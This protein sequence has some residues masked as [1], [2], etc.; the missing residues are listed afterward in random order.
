MRSIGRKRVWISLLIIVAAAVAAIVIFHRSEP[1]VTPLPTVEVEP[2]EVDD[3][4][5]Y[6]EFV[7]RIRAQQFVEVRARPFS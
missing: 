1:E 4:N 7:G 5:I 3:V 2:V 6:G